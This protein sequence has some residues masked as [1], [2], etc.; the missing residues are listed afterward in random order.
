MDEKI[1]FPPDY[2]D[3]MLP[4]EARVGL[5]QLKKYPEIICK[6]REAAMYYDKNLAAKKGWIKPPLIDG[7]TYSRY[8]IRVDNRNKVLQEY[9]KMGIELGQLI[10]YS[11][12]NM[13]T[14]QIYKR[15]EYPVSL[16]YSKHTINFPIWTKIIV[17]RF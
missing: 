15:N 12:P 16:E 7:A 3:Q 1:H 4:I 2:L 17:D 10:E 8:V 6:R 11:V 14:Y 9:K 13:K 5:E